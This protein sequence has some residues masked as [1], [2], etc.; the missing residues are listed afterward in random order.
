MEGAAQRVEQ[1]V[2]ACGTRVLHS[3]NL[4]KKLAIRLADRAVL[5]IGE[6]RGLEAV[7]L[8]WKGS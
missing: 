2:S 5:V 6:A 7:A 4:A 3:R 8:R 1:V